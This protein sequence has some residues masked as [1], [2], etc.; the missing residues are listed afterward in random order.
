MSKI[1]ITIEIPEEAKLSFPATEERG[2]TFEEKVVAGEVAA[3]TPKATRTKKPPAPAATDPA[4]D[5]SAAPAEVRQISTGEARKD[6]ANPDPLDD[7]F[8][9]AET[10][11][12]DKEVSD[13]IIR[14]K[15]RLNDV[16]AIKALIAK[17]G[18][19]H[20]S[21]IPQPVRADFIKSLEGLK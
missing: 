13:A 6:P 9:A 14:A 15:A 16:T 19:K 12:T 8:T 3:A 18:V 11:V 5:P 10:P 7:P 20:Y 1:V 17:S 21:E 4:G 2:K